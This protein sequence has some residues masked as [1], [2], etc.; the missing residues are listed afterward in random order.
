MNCQTFLSIFIPYQEINLFAFKDFTLYF[1]RKNIIPS[2]EKILLRQ[3]FCSYAYLLLK[4]LANFIVI[5]LLLHIHS[6]KKQS[7][8]MVEHIH[9][10][11]SH[12]LL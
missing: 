5:S 12:S 7:S 2:L 6:T 11:E 1:K 10:E 3:I 9:F 4:P 8:K